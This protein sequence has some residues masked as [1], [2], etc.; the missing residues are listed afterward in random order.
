MSRKGLGRRWGLWASLAGVTVV[1]MIGAH[2]SQPAPTLTVSAPLRIESSVWGAGTDVTL[3]IRCEGSCTG[4]TISVTLLAPGAS[5][6]RIENL[7]PEFF[8][9][10]GVQLLWLPPQDRELEAA[11]AA[12]SGARYVGLDFDWR[13]IQPNPGQY[14]WKD[15]D[16]VVALAKQYGLQLVPMLLYTPRWAS[17]A[18]FAPLDYHRAPPA[19]YASFRDFVYNVVRRYKPNGNSPLTS[20]G[21]GITDWVIWNEPNV[22]SSQD[23]PEPG[24]FWTGSLPEYLQLLRAGYEGAHAADPDCNV[25]NGGLADV[26]W[27]GGEADLITALDRFYDP[28]GD[29]DARDGGRAFFDT[30]NI[31]TYQLGAPDA[32]WYE[33]RL[34]AVL[35][36]MERFGD[37]GKSIWITET[38]YGSVGFEDGLPV[39]AKARTAFIDEQTQ[40]DSVSLV[41]RTCAAFGQ[42]ERVFW[43]SLRDYYFSAPLAN[44]PMEA[45]FGL[46]RAD[47]SPKPAYLAYGQMTGGIDRILTMTGVVGEE[48]S[49]HVNVPASFVTRPG[50]YTVFATLDGTAPTVVHFYEVSFSQAQ[51]ED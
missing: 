36:V 49:A 9:L 12:A 44:I 5:R 41:Y 1:L 43:W 34:E 24:N 30:L 10:S 33:D 50:I 14:V 47:W 22:R 27:A 51:D 25:L 40:A 32:A 20:D 11:L 4:Q 2:T 38:G 7:A 6:P 21:Y 17:T 13:R 42:V 45:H 29:G 31:H 39:G 19:D 15:T 28:D 26:F 18:P 35:G 3:T 16:Q 46:L 23:A 8:G 37:A 48:G